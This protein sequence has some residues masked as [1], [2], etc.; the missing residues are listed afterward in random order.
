MTFRLRFFLTQKIHL[1]CYRIC[2]RS[3]SA[4]VTYHNRCFELT[5]TIPNCLKS[6]K[7][8][9]RHSGTP[10]CSPDI[11]S[12]R[13]AASAWPITRHPSTASSWPM[14]AATHW[15]VTVYFL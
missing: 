2:A 14:T 10:F 9:L 8:K 7:N 6:C 15:W 3:L 11:T 4:I 5:P 13:T 12:Q 1:I